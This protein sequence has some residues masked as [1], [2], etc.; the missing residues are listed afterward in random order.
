[1]LVIVVPLII[2]SFNPS[3]ISSLWFWFFSS[4]GYIYE[5]YYLNNKTKKAESKQT[6]KSKKKQKEARGN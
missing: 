6:L 3:G 2:Q 4:R 5:L 1:M